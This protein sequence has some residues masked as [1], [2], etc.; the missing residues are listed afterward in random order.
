[1]RVLIIGDVQKMAT[2]FERQG[3]LVRLFKD[4]NTFR[5]VVQEVF[6]L[7]TSLP[8]VVGDLALIR[9][10]GRLAKFLEEA[11]PENMIC[12]ASRDCFDSVVLARISRRI[13]Q[14]TVPSFTGQIDSK[15]RKEALLSYPV[16]WDLLLQHDP[17]F[18]PFA[19]EAVKSPHKRRLIEWL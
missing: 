9:E 5:T 14:P 18:L 19:L 6:S 8:V 16:R 3:A 13:K 11:V 10:S 4:T 12:L 1:M 2:D 7:E 15:K 17:F